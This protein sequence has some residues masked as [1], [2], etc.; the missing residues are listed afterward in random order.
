MPPSAN[1]ASHAQLAQFPHP[2]VPTPRNIAMHRRIASLCE[3]V[4][5]LARF[6]VALRTVVR[7]KINC[8]QFWTVIAVAL[9]PVAI[10]NAYQVFDYASAD[11]LVAGTGLAPGFPVSFSYALASVQDYGHAN[12]FGVGTQIVGLPGAP[13]DSDDFV[14]VGN[15]SL[16]VN[17]TGTYNFFASTDD[18]SR[19]RIRINNGPVQQ[20]IT[21]NVLSA[22]HTAGSDPLVLAAGDK[23]DFDWMWFERAGEAAGDFFYNRTGVD[24]LIGDP[25]QGLSLDGGSFTGKLYK[26]EPDPI[27]PPPPAPN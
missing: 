17:T 2:P 23:L 5:Q 21:D 26:A 15:G 9:W 16:T 11:M 19:V 14:F 25:A 3:A 4:L 1:G 24:A 22:I 12:L 20:I 10:A 27:P 8:L 18:G 13:T 7:R 6:V